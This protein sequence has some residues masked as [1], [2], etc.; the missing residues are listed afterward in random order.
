MA[1]LCIDNQRAIRSYLQHLEEAEGL[2]PRTVDEAARAI[3]GYEAFTNLKEFRRFSR[4]DAIAFKKML[5]ARDGRAA[6][7]RSSRAT[8][9]TKL[10]QVKKFFN[11]LASQPGYKTRIERT[12]VE[13]LNIS[14]RDARLASE[15]GDKP[16]PTM[17]QIRHVIMS[18]PSLTDVELR[19]R[20]LLACIVVTGVRVAACISLR[21]KHV[22]LNRLR[23]EQ[24]A[25]EVR[26]KASKTLST[27][28]FQVD[29][30]LVRIF[31]EWVRH[32]RDNL[33]WGDN[34]PLFPCTMIVRSEVG[35]Q[36]GGLERR[37]WKT[38]NTVWDIF[39]DAFEAAGMPHFTPHSFRRTIARLGQQRCRNPEALKAW[40]LNLGHDEIATTWKSYAHVPR[41]RRAE[42]IRQL[43]PLAAPSEDLMQKYGPMLSDPF[44]QQMLD[45]MNGGQ[46]GSV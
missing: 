7:E 38:A 46:G 41:E 18:M 24:D 34:D 8:V 13:Y 1:S 45:R 6:G 16:T 25:E 28:F 36:T 42:L 5:L 35:F 19:N 23:I 2:A 37:S 9:V 43:R 26:T 14:A 11:W 27:D 40:S 33:L 20:A 12:D 31:I 22:D 21:L 17:E 4:K 3:A 32:L 39:K 10:C 44:V 30:D 15:P 29:D